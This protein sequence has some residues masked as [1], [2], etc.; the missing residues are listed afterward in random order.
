MGMKTITNHERPLADRPPAEAAW[1]RF[2]DN[3]CE[4]TFRA[5]YEQTHALVWTLCR[6]ILKNPDDTQ[7]AFQAVYC[8]L[9][10]MARE[11]RGDELSGAPGEGV[12]RLAVRESNNL[13]MQR[14]RRGEKEILMEQIPVV[15]AAERSAA[16]LAQERQLR[17]QVEA[18]ISTLPETLRVPLLLHYFDGL[19]HRQIAAALDLPA[20]TVS[21]RLAKGQR[22]LEPKLRKAGLGAVLMVLGTIAARAAPSLPPAELTADAVYWRIEAMLQLQGGTAAGGAGA[23]SAGAAADV[24]WAAQFL[25]SRLG[26]LGLGILLLGGLTFLINRTHAWLPGGDDP[27]EKPAVTA[28][29]PAETAHAVPCIMMQMAMQQ[30]QRAAMNQSAGQPVAGAPAP[31]PAV[32]AN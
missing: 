17:E 7:D 3:P 21:S 4:A 2:F 12:Y 22:K 26:L 32:A 1:Q 10:K 18:L 5:L 20:S 30:A 19:S 15:A 13:R 9:L 27:A 11:G 25:T 16:D 31:P 23:G 8:R 6:R 28:E 14:R 24:H 29:G